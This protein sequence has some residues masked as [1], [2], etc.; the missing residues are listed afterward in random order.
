[1]TRDVQIGARHGRPHGRRCV[2]TSGPHEPGLEPQRPAGRLAD[3]SNLTQRSCRCPDL[4][5]IGF[6]VAPIRALLDLPRKIVLDKRLAF[7]AYSC[8]TLHG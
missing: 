3:L 6:V 5:A 1:M 7:A 4:G 8:F 2:A